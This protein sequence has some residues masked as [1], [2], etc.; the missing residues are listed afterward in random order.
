M[1]KKIKKGVVTKE[2][3]PA[4]GTQLVIQELRIIAP[5]RSQKDI[6]DFKQGI[7][8]AESVFYPIFVKLFDLYTD[9]G[10]DGFL[11]GLIEKRI[12]AI[13]N[14][15]LRYDD[16]SG[17]CVDDMDDLIQSLEFRHVVKT[18]METEF[19]GRSGLEFVPG[20]KIQIEDIPRKHIKLE[21][22]VISKDQ[23]SNEGTPYEGVSN[24]WIMG[25]KRALG[26]L[27]KCA[28]YSIWKRGAFGEW[29]QYI[30]IFGQPVR[31]IY[32]DAYDTKTKM[33]LK[34]VLD[35]SGSSLAM[36]IPKQAQFDMKD[37]KQSNGDGQ[38]QD[39]FR[40]ACNEEMSVLILGNTESTASS[41]SSGYAQSKEHGKQQLEKT[42][43]DLKYVANML[44]SE[45][46][47]SILRSYGYPVVDGGKFVYEKE[48]NVEELFQRIDIDT[49]IKAAG[50]PIEDD[51]FYN[52][53]GIPK[54]DNYDELK[55]KQEADKAAMNN[56]KNGN[57]PP[58]EDPAPEDPPTPAKPKKKKVK[59]LSAAQTN[60]WNHMRL[61]LADFFDP[62]P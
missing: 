53:Y 47:I 54:P 29:A 25:Q 27:H 62:A 17:K 32:Y 11:T 60:F 12:D 42:K 31:I 36:M 15:K 9:I 58:Q 28:P 37:G 3:G 16:A 56:I 43:S 61:M 34:E 48:I 35:T 55:A 21:A 4:P 46:F 1:A 23:W 8:S 20:P 52:T 38:L 49:K 14:K 45:K 39:K 59:N 26:L 2:A 40:M 33:E 5:D 24:L 44:N 50:V 13:L 10:V 7:I 30:E 41:K 51:Y 6:Q 22:G 57:D 19:W 18:I